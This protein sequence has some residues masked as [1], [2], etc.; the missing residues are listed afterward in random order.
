[1]RVSAEESRTCRTVVGV[2]LAALALLA[3]PAAAQAYQVQIS[4]TGAGQVTET[5][6]ANLVGSSCASPPSTPT[7]SL[8]RTCAAG[9]TSGD[10]GW[11]WDV[12]YVATAAPGYTFVRWQS[13]P[14][15]SW[16]PVICDRSDPPATGATYT[17]ASCK[18]R[19][20]ENLQTRAVFEDTTSPAAPSV[21]AAPSGPVGGSVGF[22]MSSGSDP[23]FSHFV[24]EV[25]GPGGYSAQPSCGGGSVTVNPPSSG[26]YTL[27][28]RSVDYSDNRSALVQRTFTADRTAPET[29]LS[30]LA[31]P[32]EGS[33]TNARSASFMFTASEPGSFQCELDDLALAACGSPKQLTSLD[34]GPHKFEVWA[35]DGVGNRDPSPAVRRWTVDTVAPE[36]AIDPATG[37]AAGSPTQATS[38]T[39]GFTGSETGGFRC[40]LDGTPL[41]DCTSPTT[42]SDLPPGPHSFSVQAVDAAGNVDPSAAE[43]Q[44]TVAA[45][46]ADD[47]GEPPAPPVDPPGLGD[48]DVGATDD[49]SQARACDAAK[50]KLGK[51]KAK[52]RK[53]RKA[54]A[55]ARRIAAA[56]RKVKRLKRAKRRA[57]AR[58]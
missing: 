43:R 50:R 30:A 39:F 45:P 18:F 21:S 54:D 4:L 40:F 58:V 32:A 6:P 22:T 3:L 14:D 20:F 41:G 38:A 42:V 16:D 31:G 36:T 7:D 11:G 57:C 48:G 46:P 1:M 28:V 24:C 37:P 12:D 27:S 52:L 29:M 53:V 33:T 25:S 2:A 44:W 47:P 51:A 35:L 19:T 8:G 26:Q 5:T 15:H 9:T 10:Y 56:E 23:T 49:G 17:G 55:T 13:T 34:D